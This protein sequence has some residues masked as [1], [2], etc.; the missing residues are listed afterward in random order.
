MNLEE[1]RRELVKYLKALGAIRSEKVERA[2]L[3]VPRE[4]FVPIELRD[5]AY[6]DTPLPLFDTGQTISAPH[7]VAYMVEVLELSE[8]LKV[9]EV[10]GG[11]GYAACIVAEVMNP[12][13]VGVKCPKVFTIE[14]DPFLVKFARDNIRR[15]GY[16]ERV[17]IVEGDGTLGLPDMS[18][19]DRI[20]VSAAATNVP[21]ALLEQLAEGGKML[22]PIGRHI[23]GQRLYSIKRVSGEFKKEFLMEVSFVPLRGHGQTF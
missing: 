3:T 8:C 15:T 21:P 16:E 9:L 11:S 14:I 6:V 4:E 5:E 7:M 22:I 18:P 2:F 23:W 12:T 20:M 13:G 10:G 17:E 19:F 1:K